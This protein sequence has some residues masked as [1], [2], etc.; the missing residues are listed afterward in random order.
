MSVP[1]WRSTGNRPAIS[2]IIRR[3][4][5]EADTAA[6]PKLWF[7]AGVRRTVIALILKII[8]CVIRVTV[9]R[10]FWCDPLLTLELPR[11]PRP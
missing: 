7:R 3:H 10:G 8:S 9:G 6:G 4:T 1:I 2:A 11:G 5:Q